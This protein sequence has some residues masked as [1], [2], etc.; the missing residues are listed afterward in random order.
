VRRRAQLV[1]FATEISDARIEPLLDQG[2]TV[3]VRR[4][5]DFDRVFID[6]A[7][8]QWGARQVRASFEETIKKGTVMY[9]ILIS[10]F[11][12][13]CALVITIGSSGCSNTPTGVT[14]A[15]EQE[16]MLDLDKRYAAGAISK[17]EYERQRADIQARSQRESLESGSPMN[18]TIRGFAR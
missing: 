11:V 17:N 9:K 1:V 2:P 15:A 18:E 6:G 14:G 12:A 5:N 7:K 13:S 3:W 16:M 10:V 8:V 4:S